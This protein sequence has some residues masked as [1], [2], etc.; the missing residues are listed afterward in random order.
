MD[1]NGRSTIGIIVSPVRTSPGRFQA[2]LASTSELLVG[3]SRQPFLDAARALIGRGYN[4]LATLEMK[5]PGSD[6][7]A[8]RGPLAKVAKLTVE[9]GPHGPRFIPF[10]TGGKTRVAAPSIAPSDGSATDLLDTKSFTGA[11]VTRETDDVG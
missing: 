3:C 6:T 10:R 4:P 8:L 11:P 9:E 2:R 1:G 7:V 5:H